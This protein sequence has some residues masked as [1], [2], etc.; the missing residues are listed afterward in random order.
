[1]TENH[2]IL[3]A[4]HKVIANMNAVGQQEINE[5]LD[6]IISE[7]EGIMTNLAE[8]IPVMDSIIAYQKKEAVRRPKIVA[9]QKKIVADQKSTLSI[10][11]KIMAEQTRILTSWK[12]IFVILAKLPK[13]RD[14]GA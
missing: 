12:K 11:K 5:T 14:Q 6:Y 7:M 8:L 9:N 10:Q 3:V 13:R 1:M 4:Y 2:K